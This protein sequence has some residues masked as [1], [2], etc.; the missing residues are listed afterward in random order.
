VYTTALQRLT[1]QDDA[2]GPDTH[3]RLIQVAVSDGTNTSVVR[4]ST[5]SVLAPAASLAVAGFPTPTT[6]GAAGTFTVTARDASGNTAP[7]YTGTVHFTSSDTRAVLPGDY[8]FTAADHG[9][10]TFSATLKTA[11]PQSI[12]ATDRTTGS[13]TGTQAGIRVN[14]ASPDHLAVATAAANP[15]VAGTPFDVTVAVQDLYGNTVTGYTG[16]VTFTSADPYGAT[17]PADYTFQPGDAGAHTFAAGATLYTAGT[18]DVTA[19]DTAGAIS[20]AANV[21]VVAA[22]AV[23]FQV[24]APAGATAGAAFDFTVTATDPYGNTDTN[25]QGTVVFST[26]DP[27]GGFNPTGYAFQPG[28]LGVATF[29]LGATLNTAGTWDVTATDTVSGIT[30][31]AYVAVSA[32]PWARGGGFPGSLVAA[33]VRAMPALASSPASA[34]VALPGGRPMDQA[35][36]EGAIDVVL[37]EMALGRSQLYPL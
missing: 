17:L 30:G 36:V 6:A 18:W 12:T 32:G 2:P 35:A 21:N 26:L 15:D 5:V 16:T 11:A 29:P 19:T 10:H 37:A 33:V 9:V 20:G 31:S 4:T 23:A 25:Y 3:D 28:D 34:P 7:G 1:Y 24:A 27:A 13:I 8:A 22:P 14:P